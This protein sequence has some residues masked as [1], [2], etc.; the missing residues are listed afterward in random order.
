MTSQMYILQVNTMFLTYDLP[1]ATVLAFS[2]WS[3][4]NKA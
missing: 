4:M 1:H 2:T 3:E